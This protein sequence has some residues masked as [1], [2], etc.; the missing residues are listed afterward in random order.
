MSVF[1]FHAR[2]NARLNEFIRAG[3]VGTGGQRRKGRAKT[4]R[5][6]VLLSLN[7]LNS[8]MV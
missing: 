4:Q 1:C 2:P 6:K 8:L 3:T 5:P 7:H